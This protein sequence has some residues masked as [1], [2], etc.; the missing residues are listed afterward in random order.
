M[1][2]E[3]LFLA[4]RL[5]FPPDRGDRIRSAHV[6]RAL[7][8][9]APVHVGCFVDSEADRAHEPTLDMLAASTCVVTRGKPLPVAGIEALLR[10]EAVSVAAY[11]SARLAR[12]VADLLA[13]G[14]IAAVYVFS[15]QIG[16]F[17]PP[18]W[19]GRTVIDLCDVDSAK[20]EAYGT[21]AAFPQ[22]WVHQREGRLL[23]AEEAR[24]A[25][26][27]DHTLLVSEEEAAL[28]RA[29]VPLARNITALGNGIDA[30]HFSPQGIF[31]AAAMS[32]EGPHLLFTGQMDYPPNVAAV[33]RMVHQV[34]PEVRRVLPYARFHIVGRAPVRAVRALDGIEGTTVH[35]AVADM[36][37][38]LGAADMVVA[39]LAI[40]R[41]VQNKVLEAMAM[42][43]PV[44]LSPEAATGIAARDGEHFSVAPDDAAFVATILRLAAMPGMAQAM[45]DAARRFVIERQSWPAMLAPL[46][47]LLGLAKPAPEQRDAA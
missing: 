2:G 25:G 40:A 41:G 43:R 27:A 29:R 47:G 1:S 21:T 9:L 11:R 7:A 5:P 38:Y 22:A 18:S 45:G 39:P 24:L 32:G 19:S 4:H 33:E 8:R 16:Q 13:S 10:G 17:V 34:M 14:R 26:R 36:R 20:F 44:V 31:P 42:A 12:W 6:L 46:A 3:I 15:G 37:P 23:S 30:D 28:L 35:G